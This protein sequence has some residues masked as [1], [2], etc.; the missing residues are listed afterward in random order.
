LGLGSWS[1]VSYLFRD[2]PATRTGPQL[3]ITRRCAPWPPK[4]QGVNY[5]LLT[6]SLPEEEFSNDLPTPEHCPLFRSHGFTHSLLTALFKP[7][8]DSLW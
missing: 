4:L 6:L 3:S 7:L 1:T 2:R 8:D 5:S